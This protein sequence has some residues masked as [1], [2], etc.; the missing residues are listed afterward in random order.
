M[1][2]DGLVIHQ[3]HACA[4][5]DLPPLLARLRRTVL[6]RNPSARHRYWS[7]AALDAFVEATYPRLLPAFRSARVGVQR[8]DLGRLALLHA[9]G[10]LYLDTDV[11]CL[12]AFGAPLVGG[13]RLTVAPEPKGQV[14]ALYGGGTYLCN[15]VMYAP[16]GDPGVA[17]CLAFVESAWAAHGAAMWA[18]AFDVLGGRLL[19]RVWQDRADL[20]DVVPAA[21]CYPINDLKLAAL[22]THAAD[23]EAARE[24]RFGD[25]A[26][27]VHWWVH[28]NFEGRDAL[29]ESESRPWPFLRALYG[30]KP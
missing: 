30:L 14:D 1:S 26:Q 22:P 20:V 23:V 6:E 5:A 25:D 24:G 19:T 3:T 21:V 18:R 4:E 9:F 12:R 13:P 28:S 7:D 15:A 2:G 29:V 17:A 16:A 11:E 27:A 10:G 8:S